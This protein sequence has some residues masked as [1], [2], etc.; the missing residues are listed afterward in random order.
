MA[1]KREK[2][3][4]HNVAISKYNRSTMA[5]YL[6]ASFFCG[7]INLFAKGILARKKENNDDNEKE[8]LRQKN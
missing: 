7:K 4:N 5:N 2:D 3:N 6:I 8:E 1:R